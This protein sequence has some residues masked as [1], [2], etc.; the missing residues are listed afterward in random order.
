MALLGLIVSN[1][2]L[3]AVNPVASF[4]TGLAL[5]RFFSWITSQANKC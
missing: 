2:V 3:M 4:V 1:L 5:D